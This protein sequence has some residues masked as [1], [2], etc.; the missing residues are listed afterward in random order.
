MIIISIYR[1]INHL[2][3]RF[4]QYIYATKQSFVTRRPFNDK[5][6]IKTKY[7]FDKS[8]G[9]VVSVRSVVCQ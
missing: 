3:S 5:K 2:V 9:D 4:K 1:D 7:P 6:A 8:S